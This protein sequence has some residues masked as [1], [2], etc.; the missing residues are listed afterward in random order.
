MLDFM[1]LYLYRSLEELIVC[2]G[3]YR[4]KERGKRRRERGEKK[5]GGEGYKIYLKGNE[6]FRY[7]IKVIFLFLFID[8]LIFCIFIIGIL[9]EVLVIKFITGGNFFKML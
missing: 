5:G 2:N 8:L 7:F 4:R 3:I 1:W 9:K 6:E